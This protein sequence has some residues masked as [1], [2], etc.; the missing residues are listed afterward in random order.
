MLVASIVLASAVAAAAAE[1]PPGTPIVLIRVVRTD[2]FDLS[3][4]ET[5]AWPYRWANAL[6]ILT[7]EQ[8]IRDL[9][10]FRVGDKLDPALLEESARLLR[11]TQFLS[12]VTITARPA[13]G[14]AEVVVETHDQWTTL[15]GVSFGLFGKR[16][17]YGASVSELNLLGWGKELNVEFDHDQ[18][19]TTTTF[20]YKD[21]LFFGSRWT[22][23]VAH[24]NASDGKL[25]A[26]RLEYPFYA[27]ATPRAG[28]GDWGKFNLTK[29]LYSGSEQV[30]SGLTHQE[31]ILLWGGL[32]LPGDGDVANRVT[33]GVFYRDVSFADWRWSDGSAYPT[34]EGRKMSGF[35][36]GFEHQSNRWVV[37]QGF[38]GWQAQEDLPLGPNWSATA[39]FSLPAFGGD[40]PRFPFLGQVHASLL[41]AKQYSWVN[42][43]AEGRA[44]QGRVDNAVAHFAVGTARLGPVGL[45]GRLAADLGHNLDG[46]VQLPL[47]ADTGLRGWEPDYFDGTSRAVANLE[48]RHQLTGELL[49]IGIIGISVFADVGRTW[50]ARVG[51]D[52]DGWRKDAGIG[53]LI[54]STRASKLRIIRIEA[55]WPDHGKGPVILVTGA[56][57][58]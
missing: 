55:G 43:A 11:D 42:L 33:V 12:P 7:R 1:V 23:A 53:L 50:G 8:F 40:E 13:E 18:E 3:D 28:G 51:P 15:V 30:V 49:H 2:I 25:D 10:L 48:W 41:S 38:R 6:H 14:G 32:R 52:T 19:R 47:G 36:I 22:L 35:E 37:A 5:S 21:P 58:F 46:N 26:F 54:E 16:V 27:L 24:A 44:E 34:P 20:S 39:G 56:P 17:H 31:N 57:I 9:L 45:R 4:P 29:Y